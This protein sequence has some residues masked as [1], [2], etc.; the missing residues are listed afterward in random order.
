M[1]VW[2]LTKQKYAAL[3]GEGARL[4]G[5]R[6]NSVGKPMVYTSS[7][8]SL[9]ILEQLVRMDIDEIPED[10]VSLQIK[11]PS[12]LRVS[13]IALNEFPANW[14]KH[15]DFTWFRQQGEQWL[16]KQHTAVLIVPSVVV[17]E[18]TNILLNPMHVDFHKI[19]LV[20][21]QAFDFDKR[22]F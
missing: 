14:K 13:H 6:W 12:K 20:R 16:A 2:R 4:Y 7:H 17:S 1:D 9:A 19:Q 15:I 5:G 11:I 3:N 21:T 18:E 22:L 10:F 8:L